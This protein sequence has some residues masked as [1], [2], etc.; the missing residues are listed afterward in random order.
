MKDRKKKQ[1]HYIMVHRFLLAK[2][3]EAKKE[4]KF[5]NRDT[6][7]RRVA[8]KGKQT[9]RIKTKHSNMVTIT[10]QHLVLNHERVQLQ[11]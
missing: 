5:I 9:C 11:Q 1:S 6:K 2:K 4:M 3:S 8:E 10:M 7:I